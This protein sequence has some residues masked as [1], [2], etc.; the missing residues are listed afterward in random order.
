MNTMGGVTVPSKTTLAL[1]HQ[2]QVTCPVDALEMEAAG[3]PQH[4]LYI[5]RSNLDFIRLEH[6]LN[7][8]CGPENYEVKVLSTGRLVNTRPD[9]FEGLDDSSDSHL[10]Y[11]SVRSGTAC[12]DVQNDGSSSKVCSEEV[13]AGSEGSMQVGHTQHT[14]TN[15]SFLPSSAS[16]WSQLRRRHLS[17]N[18]TTSAFNRFSNSNN[19]NNLIKERKE[20]IDVNNS[21]INVKSKLKDKVLIS[22]IKDTVTTNKDISIKA[23]NFYNNFKAFSII[24]N[25]SIIVDF[26]IIITKYKIFNYIYYINKLVKYLISIVRLL[27]IGSR[28]LKVNN[29]EV[30]YFYYNKRINMIKL[31]IIHY[32]YKLL[33]TILKLNLTTYSNNLITLL[34]LL[35]FKKVY[36]AELPLYFRKIQS[37]INWT[38]LLSIIV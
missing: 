7:D 3:K 33:R 9:D 16:G 18:P 4:E 21:L 28:E 8:A 1:Y 10:G 32:I 27:S 15:Q 35:I 12:E 34:Y 24:K 17:I 26:K 38:Y 29:I 30:V 23:F 13:E 22:I 6:Q 2:A 11:S 25:K 37:F 36:I 20:E 31:N 5:P 19:S 14:V